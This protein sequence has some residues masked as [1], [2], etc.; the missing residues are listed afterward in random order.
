MGELFRWVQQS[1]CPEEH[2]RRFGVAIRFVFLDVEELVFVLTFGPRGKY[3]DDVFGLDD[4]P[5]GIWC[6]LVVSL[7][8]DT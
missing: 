3:G 5:L 4:F 2:G 8:F 6:W 1:Q 7:C